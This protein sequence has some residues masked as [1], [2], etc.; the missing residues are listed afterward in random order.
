M[1]DLLDEIITILGQTDTSKFLQQVFCIFL[2]KSQKVS[3]LC[4]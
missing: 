2:A 4:V 3:L 1:L